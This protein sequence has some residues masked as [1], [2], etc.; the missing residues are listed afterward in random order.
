MRSYVEDRWHVRDAEGA[1]I[2]S[3][4]WG[5]GKR[6]RARYHDA[7]GREHARHFERKRDAERWLAEVSASVLT[8]TYVDPRASRLT[9]REYAETWLAAQVHREATAALYRNHLER[10][11]YPVWGDVPLGSILTSHVQA[12]VKGLTLPVE[13]G[14]DALAPATVGVI[15]TVA[16][17]VFRA[18]V[19]DRKLAETP[20]RDIALPEVVKTRVQPLT[21]AQVDTL[22]DTVP[23]GLRA[24]VILAAGTGMRQGEVL[25]LTRDRLRLLGRDPA[26]T[27][28]R[29]L[30]TKPGGSTTFG[31][32]KTRA[33]Y[34]T[35]PL[36][37]VV[38]AA[39]NDHL[40]QRDVGDSDLL[41]TIDGKGIT[42]QRFGHLWRPAARAAGLNEATGTGMHALRH[43]YASLLIRYGESVKTV[44][45]RLGHKSATE[46]L[47]TYGH[48]W[49]DSDDR[50]RDAVDSVLGARAD[51]PRTD[52]RSIG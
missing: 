9:F 1:T 37:R 44:Q 32:L 4:R 20:C 25:G 36:P 46:T 15:Y 12:W 41:F 21:T 29:Q 33:S 47:D 3:A 17:S 8:G 40:A 43:Y 51:S 28:D 7:A 27:V 14:R 6:W 22:A 2:R 31:P 5:T 49:A 24:L 23:A 26:V 19:H 10:H 35:I 16:A 48:M 52:G 38:V 18:A 30:V 13:G 11:A 39:L 34:R 42:R 45:D 50:T